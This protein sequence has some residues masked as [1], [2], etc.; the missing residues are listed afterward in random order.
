MLPSAT[1]RQLRCACGDYFM[2]FA[3]YQSGKW[4]SSSHTCCKA[5]HLRNKPPRQRYPKHGSNDAGPNPQQVDAPLVAAATASFSGHP[6]LD[7]R[8]SM[9][10]ASGPF[11]IDVPGAVVDSGAQVC[12]LPEYAVKGFPAPTNCCDPSKTPVRMAN[13]DT[14]SVKGV[15]MGTVSAVSNT[16]ERLYH[17]G[18]IYIA[19][20]IRD[21]YISCD[22]MRDLR[23]INEHFPLPGSGDPPSCGLCV[24]AAKADVPPC[25]CPPRTG[26]PPTPPAL[27]FS[28]TVDNIPRMKKW[29]LQHFASSTFN[30]CPHQVLPVMEGPPLEIHLDPAAKPRYVSTPSTVPLHWQDKVKTDMTAP[31]T[32]ADA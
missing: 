8:I 16:G 19:S 29:L 18:K 5:C 21:C 9:P 17:T 28:A 32:E 13:A 3:Q 22:A 20:G 30:Q 24:A 14:I 1:P 27:P 11:D 2:D 12:L 26:P 25:D 4:N 31:G 10:S 23:I 6:R 7:V 15:V